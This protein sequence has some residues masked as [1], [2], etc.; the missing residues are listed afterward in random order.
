MSIMRIVIGLVFLA[1]GFR[2]IAGAFVRRWRMTWKRG[3][4]MSGASH[5]VSAII[6]CFAAVALVCMI[7]KNITVAVLL[8]LVA[9]LVL[10]DL[11]TRNRT[12]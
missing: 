8:S 6:F 9:T 2:F 5:F 11:L 12:R 1:I 3:I 10:V 4:P 7:N